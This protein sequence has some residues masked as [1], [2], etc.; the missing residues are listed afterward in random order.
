MLSAKLSSHSKVKSFRRKLNRPVWGST[1][2]G[3]TD[4]QGKSSP[5]KLVCHISARKMV[6]LIIAHSLRGAGEDGKQACPMTQST[7]LVD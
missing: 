7:L 2:F 4:W 5:V 3:T 1:A 6:S